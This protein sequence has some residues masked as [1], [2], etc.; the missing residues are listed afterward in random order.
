MG[1]LTI[2]DGGVRCLTGFGFKGWVSLIRDG[3]VWQ[4]TFREEGVGQLT[5]NCVFSLQR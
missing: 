3:G 1:Q 5:H 2:R 4:L